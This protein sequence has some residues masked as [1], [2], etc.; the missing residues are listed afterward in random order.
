MALAGLVFVAW[1]LYSDAFS[2][3]AR[4]LEPED[5]LSF[6]ATT[7]TVNDSG[8]ESDGT[9]GDGIC[10]TENDEVP[11]CTLRAAIEEANDPETDL[12]DVSIDLTSINGDTIS[13][14]SDLPEIGSNISS[15][16]AVPDLNGRPTISGSESYRIFSIGIGATVNIEALDLIDADSP[17]NGGAILNA[18]DLTLSN[19]S[20]DGAAANRGGCIYNEGVLD[21]VGTTLSNCSSTADGGAILNTDDAD[22]NTSVT[23][24]G[25]SFIASSNSAGSSGDGIFNENLGGIKSSIFLETGTLASA[26]DGDLTDSIDGGLV[27]REAGTFLLSAANDYSGSTLIQG[28]TLQ[29]GANDALPTSTALNVDSDAFFDLNGYNQAVGALT[30]EGTVTSTGNGSVFFEVAGS[31][32]TT[33][34]GVITDDDDEGGEIAASALSPAGDATLSLTKSGSGTLTLSGNS[35]YDGETYIE[36]GTLKLGISNALPTAT[37]LYIYDDAVFD[38]AGFN[39]EIQSLHDVAGEGGFAA[40]QSP[41]ALTEAAA[42]TLGSGTLTVN[43]PS[44]LSEGSPDYG[45]SI[46]GSGGQLVKGNDG[47]FRLNGTE[48][49]TWATTVSGGILALTGGSESDTLPDAGAVTVNSP[50]TLRI[51]DTEET[52]GSLSGNG[53]VEF[54]WCGEC[55]FPTLTLGSGS[56]S[57]DLTGEGDL[58]KAGA[59]TFSMSGIAAASVDFGVESGTFNGNGTVNGSTHMSSGKTQGTGSLADLTTNAGTATAGNSPGTLTVGTLDLS[60]GTTFEIEI[61][62]LIPGSGYDQVIVTDTV[63]LDNATL[64]LSC[65]LSAGVVSGADFTII[66]RQSASFDPIGTFSGLAEGGIVTSNFCGSGLTATISYFGDTGNDVVISVEE[67]ATETPTPTSTPTATNTPTS[68]PT[69]TNTPTRTPTN[70]P[71]RTPTHTHTPTPTPTPT[72]TA[73]PTPADPTFPAP[74]ITPSPP[75]NT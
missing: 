33:F 22:S 24:S 43:A 34:S 66:D 10:D 29:I 70:T 28:G 69:A 16:L 32:N 41:D 60:G 14:D 59:G 9:P 57:G 39:Q 45:G 53:T 68:T 1:L 48:S 23:I 47:Y 63:N 38:L 21:L 51:D 30:G 74:A 54:S 35:S 37:W 58:V 73:T 61:E 2:A 64:L 20:I 67:E 26:L 31:A 7:I 75:P 17:G 42:I 55:T 50:G 52:I 40:V 71:T 11:I 19:V 65:S 56:F 12:S 4:P 44:S 36:G 5:T 62:G 6:T 49:G 46:S 18:G 13:L 25:D 8:D 72:P 27:K 15:I 3:S